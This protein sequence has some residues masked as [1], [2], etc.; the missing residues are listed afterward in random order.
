MAAYDADIAII[1]GGIVGTTAAIALQEDGF[2]TLVIEPSEAGAGTAGGSA[3][4]L[5]DGEI[6][7]LGDARMLAALPKMLLDP[8]GP[9]VI[10]PAFAP[11]LAGWGL[12]FLASMRDATVQRIVAALADLNRLAIDALVQIAT[13]A[14][15]QN[16]IVRGGG[17]KV[18]REE[19]TLASLEAELRAVEREGIAARAIG[20][21]ELRAL[22]PG[23][24]GDLAGA[25][26]YPNSAHCIDL[27]AFG[28]ALAARVRAGGSIVT[29]R[30]KELIAKDGAWT[31]VCDEMR[32]QAPRV[33][34]A[35]GHASGDVLRPLGYRVP[36]A[37]GRG[38][39]LMLGEPGVELRHPVI[40]QEPHFAATPMRDGLRLAG[41]MEFAPA[42]RPPDMRRAEMLFTTASPYMQGLKRGR[43]STWMGVRPMTP[44][45][46]P[47]IGRAR[48]DN[49]YYAFGHGHLGL[50][51][52]AITARCIADLIAGASPPVSLAPFDLARFQ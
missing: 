14:G 13:T 29:A 16:L 4:Y 28:G 39:H 24:A 49:L 6:F 8:L 31:I 5:H 42:N 37:P 44:D 36:L 23:L 50:T 30:A 51:Q 3:G 17:L 47:M 11:K 9:L 32:F 12:R 26:W 20:A 35:A 40:F 48:H 38:Y 45:S 25:I 7:P 43:A 2:R 33:L 27:A 46:L 18:C 1:G 10:R 21:A 41:T 22:E 52:S 15:A 19:R 34:V